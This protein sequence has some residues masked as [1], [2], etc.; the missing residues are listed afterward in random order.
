MYLPSPLRYSFI[1]SLKLG[2]HPQRSGDTLTQRS[3]ITYFFVVRFNDPLSFGLPLLA[4]YVLLLM[5][6]LS[7]DSKTT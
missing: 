4:W 2:F 1:P 5:E 6:A 7:L 3:T